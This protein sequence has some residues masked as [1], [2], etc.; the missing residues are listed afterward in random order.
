[1]KIA[2]VKA[3]EAYT[4]IPG[5]IGRYSS[6][7]THVR[8]LSVTPHVYDSRE[9]KFVESAARTIGKD[10]AGRMTGI[11]IAMPAF[12]V[13]EGIDLSDP[14]WDG[15]TYEQVTA[16][17][18]LR[19]D[20]VRQQELH[21]RELK[22]QREKES[23]EEATRQQDA[24]AQRV[25]MV[26][27]RERALRTVADAL[28]VETTWAVESGARPVDK[29][30]VWETIAAKLSVLAAQVDAMNALADSMEREAPQGVGRFLAAEI[31]DRL[32]ACLPAEPTVY[33]EKE[34]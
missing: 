14:K 33:G 27:R 31:R 10:Y 28:G 13:S 7:G 21:P 23:V 16:H 29:P 3:G 20:V 9:R 6:P 22:A 18:D 4:Y 12:L 19:V 34:N 15:I 17:P 5:R 24:S 1:M 2:D 30:E 25:A 32:A 11:L 26:A 8:A